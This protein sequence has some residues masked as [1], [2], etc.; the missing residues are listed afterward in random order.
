MPRRV[1][2]RWG[3]VAFLVAVAPG[4]WAQ[5]GP[6]GFRAEGGTAYYQNNDGVRVVSPW[7]ELRQRV[8]EPVRVGAA[9]H[10][11]IIS[12]ASVD[13]V[14]S[15]TSPVRER[16]YEGHVDVEGRWGDVR[17]DGSYT[18]S[19]ERDTWAHTAALSGS[20][21]LLERNL[22]LALAVSLG[23]DRLGTAM[24]PRSR[25]RARHRQRV[26][27]TVTQVLGRGTV[28]S[29]A[30]TLERLDGMLASPYRM[31][32]LLPASP[33]LWRRDSAQW[34]RE[35]HPGE[36]MRH[37]L[38]VRLRHALTRR[39]FVGARYRGYLDDWAMRGNAG[40]LRVGF[41][42]GNG[43][44]LTLAN[45]FAWQSRVSFFRGVYT[46]NRDYITRDRRLSTMLDDEVRL[47]V[48][49]QH[50]GLVV[51]VRGVF[52]W[53]RYPEFWAFEGDRLVPMPDTL[54]G[55]AQVALSWDL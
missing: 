43:W 6:A 41:D 46:V 40:E 53:T 48:R 36:R 27:A 8:V 20:L 28:G 4:A 22:T 51:L 25:W 17:V 34:V 16:R 54:G 50:G 1:A 19:F 14:T 38:V 7:V 15:A 49:W 32:P 37:A 24:E 3:A 44:T 9:F 52:E 23:F 35:R 18:G 33:E 21:D 39:V 26:Q 13:V 11:D 45:R 2:A 47:D 10:A 5:E 29:L 55:I 12:A 42:A 31:V 30:Y